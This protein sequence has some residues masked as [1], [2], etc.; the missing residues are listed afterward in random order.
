MLSK[1]SYQ[2]PYLV[3]VSGANNSKIIDII[4][5]KDLIWYSCWVPK[6]TFHKFVFKSNNKEF[7]ELKK[8]LFDISKII[9]K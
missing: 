5:K 6:N 3:Q 4:N 9:K 8:I 7:F 1:L 2:S